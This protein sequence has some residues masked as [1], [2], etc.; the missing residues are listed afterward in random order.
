MKRAATKGA[1]SLALLGASLACSPQSLEDQG[2]A[3]AASVTDLSPSRANVYACLTCHAEGIGETP[4]RI[5]PG[6]PLAG[7]TSRSSFWGGQHNDLLA[8]INAC[9]TAFMAA[10]AP[11]EV[12]SQEAQALYAYLLSLEPGDAGPIPFTVQRTIVDLP[13]GSAEAGADLYDAACGSC[14]G[15]MHTG[16]GR[17][18]AHVPILPEDSVAEHLALGYSERLI[19]LVFIEKVRHGPFLG[20]GGDMPPLSLEVLND[21]GLGDI[22]EALGVTGESP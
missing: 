11:L 7:A 18:S 22:L 13:R 1:L 6:A 4:E 19:R 5:L 15:A 2:A 16:E 3:L 12:D 17:L 21:E 20:Y 9:R 14:H 8:S 10:N